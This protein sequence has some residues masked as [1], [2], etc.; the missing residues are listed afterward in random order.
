MPTPQQQE[1]FNRWHAFL[2][3][4]TR[5]LHDVL[6]EAEGGMRDL[7]ASSPTD[8]IPVSNVLGAL[9]ARKKNLDKKLYDTWS[10]QLVTQLADGASNH[11]E[12]RGAVEY[13][14]GTLDTAEADMQRALAWMEETFEAFRVRWA[15]AA[16]RAMWPHVEA[17]LQKPVGC[18]NCG[19]PLQPRVRNRA[20]SVP[21]PA[22]R[23]VNQVTPEAVVYSYFVAAPHAFAEEAALPKRFAVS[24]QRREAEAWRA[25]EKNRTGSWPDEPVES[26][27]RWEALER[28][29]WQSYVGVRAQ[30][31]PMTP[32]EQQTF[33]Q[34]RVQPL[35]DDL[36]RNPVWRRAH[37]LPTR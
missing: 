35:L 37:G 27:R 26:L 14:G 9:T 33:L 18:S 23:S 10:S 22:C 6:S 29:Y 32:E 17:G 5:R 21:C 16:V 2:G 36:E 11:A 24:K 4:V 25:S 15:A 20:D 34:S 19:G 30:V 3:K 1:L 31:E 7:V 8:Q 13:S 12:L 28:D